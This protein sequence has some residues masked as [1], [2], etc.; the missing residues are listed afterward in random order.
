MVTKQTLKIGCLK[1]L[2]GRCVG[3]VSGNLGC[4]DVLGNYAPLNGLTC[5]QYGSEYY[6]TG[7]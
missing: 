6:V 3:W 1:R 7:V 2:T 5:T 4:S